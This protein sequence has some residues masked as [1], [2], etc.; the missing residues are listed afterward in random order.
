MRNYFIVCI[1]LVA[2]SLPVIAQNTF[3]FGLMPSVNLSKKLPKDWSLNFKAESMQSLYNEVFDYEYQ[4][5]DISLIAA[6]RLSIRTSIGAGY[7]MRIDDEGLK[8]RTIQQI[9][10]VSALPF[11]RLSHRFR[12]DQTF[13]RNYDTE[14]RFRYR[15]SAEVPLEGQS[16]DPLEFYLKL[17]NEY[18]NSFQAREYDLEIR[19][20]A[21]LGFA[22]TPDSELE[23]GVDYRIDSFINGYSRNRV[24]LGI[25][26]YQ[27]L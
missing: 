8:N 11:F 18:L 17:N 5:T 23:F 21:F 24:W 12:A 22:L 6:K 19:A 14:F 13:K 7:L 3:Q 4:L 25:G 15:I 26:F 2:V 10:I 27:S 20:A 9:S 1:F 16:V